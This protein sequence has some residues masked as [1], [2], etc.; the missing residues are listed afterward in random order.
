MKEDSFLYHLKIGAIVVGA[1]LLVI[2][3]ALLPVPFLC[4]EALWAKAI[5]GAFLLLYIIAI[6]SY[7][8]Y[9]ICRRPTPPPPRQRYKL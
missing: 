9:L 5:G 1:M 2:V 8:S 7:F 6:P 3:G 4:M